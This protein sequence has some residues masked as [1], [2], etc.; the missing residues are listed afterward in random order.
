MTIAEQTLQRLKDN[1]DKLDISI[2]KL[3]RG[4]TKH[5][6][7]IWLGEEA[8]MGEFY[9]HQ[10][11][12]ESTTTYDD[13]KSFTEV[14]VKFDITLKTGEYFDTTGDIVWTVKDIAHSPL[15]KLVQIYIH[16]LLIEVMQSD[17]STYFMEEFA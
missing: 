6:Y 9:L 15:F 8:F 3:E 13:N 2:F 5:D 14:G 10:T 17:E 7:E 4:S 1:K 12:Q 16:T 11:T